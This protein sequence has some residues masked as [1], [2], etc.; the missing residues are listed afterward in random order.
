M[1]T[2]SDRLRHAISFELIG[3]ALVTPLASWVF[4]H[5]LGDMGLVALVSATLATIWT[6]QFNLGFDHAMLRLRGDVRKT[7]RIRILHAA[8]FEIGLML[9]LLPYI[10]WSLGISLIEA[11]VMDLSF[12]VFYFFYA[13]GFNW[14]YDLLFPLPAPRNTPD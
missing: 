5:P 1:R 10:I 8:L 4:G 7:P 12:T 11:V 3:L 13:L 2:R 14:G 6:Y 9:V